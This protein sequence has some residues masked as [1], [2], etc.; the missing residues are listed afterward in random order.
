M[1]LTSH[2]FFLG[3]ISLYACDN[4]RSRLCEVFLH[5]LKKH[6]NRLV[7]RLRGGVG[8]PAIK[9]IMI[10]NFKFGSIL[11]T[12]YL[13]KYFYAELFAKSLFSVK[14]WRKVGKCWTMMVH[15]PWSS[16]PFTIWKKELQKRVE[17]MSVCQTMYN[18]T[19]TRSLNAIGTS[20][21]RVWDH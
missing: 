3:Q 21:K 19:K 12:L 4:C 17:S 14:S 1:Y 15:V 13:Q 7:C 6:R 2:A 20:I 10:Y 16:V 8:G 18:N 5:C 11:S 9:D